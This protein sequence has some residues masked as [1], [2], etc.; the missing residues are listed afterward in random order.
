ME[1]LWFWLISAMFAT[2]SVL[3]G[4]DF[5]VGALHLFVAKSNTER[6]TVL[7]AVLPYW[8][9]N[10]VWLVAAGGSLMLAFPHVLASGL[11]G[12]YLPMFMVLWTLTLRG[13]AIEFRSHVDE[14]LWQSF[15]DFVFAVASTTMPVLLGVAL[16]NVIRGV[17][18]DETGY[19]NIPLF[20][21]FTV[22]NPLGVLDWFT[23]LTGLFV[24]S[25][26][27]GH[28]ALYLVLKCE[29]TVRA[30][31]IR[32]AKPLWLIAGALGIG[33]T[34]AISRI[35]SDFFA[36]LPHSAGACV[37]VGVCISGI[38]ALAFGF[39]RGRF[40][41]AFA[42]STGFILG[43]LGATAGC[44]FPVM[45]RSSLRPE[46]SLTAHNA[47]SGGYELRAGIIW[48]LFALPLVLAYFAFV[49]WVHSRK[50]TVRTVLNTG[51]HPKPKA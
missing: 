28:G 16:G 20:S 39:R 51:Q 11:S 49:F 32:A 47:S 29:G 31:A 6:K 10:E 18:L 37:F 4:F 8:D 45:L 19:F 27:C 1:T 41:V 2:Y 7:G 50:F 3:D 40:G 12:F 33:C 34:L 13:I 21:D 42:G 15:W 44:L 48:W 25:T 14:Q 26:L 22:H 38:A 5:G 17:P 30:R 36:R 35:N 46:W 23:G 43:I 9:G 24:L